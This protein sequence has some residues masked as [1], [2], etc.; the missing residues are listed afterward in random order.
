MN[1]YY[2]YRFK[3]KNDEI[4]YIGKAKTL[5]SR[6]SGHNHLPMEC[7]DSIDKI[8]YIELNNQSEGSMYE[9][10]WI[11]KLSPKYNTEYNK[12][13]SI[14]FKL[15]KKE[16]KSWSGNINYK[17][18]KHKK[19]NVTTV[20]YEYLIYNLNIKKSYQF[21]NSIMQ[22]RNNKRLNFSI[23]IDDDTSYK[24]N[25][26][27]EEK[28]NINFDFFKENIYYYKKSNKYNIVPIKK[29]VYCNTGKINYLDDT[30]VYYLDVYISPN[31]TIK[32]STNNIENNFEI[33]KILNIHSENFIYKTYDKYCEYLG[34]HY[35]DLEY[36]HKGE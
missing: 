20:E 27:A 29:Y 4:I 19:K 18:P 23:T 31:F 21:F 5:S 34:F 11:N 26:V 35:E 2:V 33:I 15:P 25:I 22:L 16:W 1:K 13:D 3:D 32:I 6:M 28:R 8:E 36:A 14:S 7:Y 30:V 17:K 12:N 10:Y 9:I 24:R